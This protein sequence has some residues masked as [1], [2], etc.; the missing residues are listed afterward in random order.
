[1]SITLLFAA[2]AALLLAP[3]LAGAQRDARVLIRFPSQLMDDKAVRSL[4]NQYSA[5]SHANVIYELCQDQFA[6][7]EAQQTY[8]KAKF[9]EVSNNYLRAFDTA[10]RA[11]TGAPSPQD[12]MKKY[13]AYLTDQQKKIVGNTSKTVR[14]KG[15]SKGGEARRAF[16]AVGEMY[17][18][19]MAKGTLPAGAVSAPANPP[20]AAT[21]PAMAPKAAS[22]TPNTTQ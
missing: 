15:C 5:L 16:K 9:T 21:Q 2:G 12:M 13:V 11:R 17:E 8:R 20:A 14:E 18:A 4:S 6:I 10:Y 3:T 19:D 1:M 22:A 7:S